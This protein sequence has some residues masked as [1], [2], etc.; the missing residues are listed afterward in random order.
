MITTGYIFRAIALCIRTGV[1]R[2]VLE[3]SDVLM[4]RIGKC[5]SK[6]EGFVQANGE[7]DCACTLSI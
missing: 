4:D 6:G 5:F 1:V 3:K 2:E 7:A